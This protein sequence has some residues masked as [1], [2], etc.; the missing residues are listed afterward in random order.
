VLKK[1]HP[2]IVEPHAGKKKAGSGRRGEKENKERPS[3]RSCPQ[4]AA[5]RGI[6]KTAKTGNAQVES[7]EQKNGGGRGGRVIPRS[8]TNAE[9]DLSEQFGEETNEKKIRVQSNLVK[10]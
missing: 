6:D 2:T 10:P 4:P 9:E 3:F 8:Y 7:S 1:S 5:K